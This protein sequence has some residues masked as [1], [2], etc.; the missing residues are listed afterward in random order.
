MV[1]TRNEHAEDRLRWIIMDNNC[2][3]GQASSPQSIDYCRKW[4][5]AN[6]IRYPQTGWQWRQLLL[7]GFSMR[8]GWNLAQETYRQNSSPWSNKGFPKSVSFWCSERRLR[9]NS[10]LERAQESMASSSPQQMC[11]WQKQTCA[12]VKAAENP[13]FS[14]KTE[15]MR[16]AGT[17]EA[18][19]KYETKQV[20]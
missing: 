1:P 19:K 18:A 2:I 10:A 20:N 17:H 14:D 7:T 13:T 3:R 5:H 6:V 9:F 11:R 4:C 16:R 8:M 12:A 15:S